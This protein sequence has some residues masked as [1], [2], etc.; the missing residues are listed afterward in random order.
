M[1]LYWLLFLIKEQRERL[2]L[3]LI[4]ARLEIDSKRISSTI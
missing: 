1:L 4:R 2:V 3:K